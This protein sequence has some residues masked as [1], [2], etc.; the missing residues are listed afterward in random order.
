MRN[1]PVSRWLKL[2]G[3]PTLSVLLLLLVVLINRQNALL[4]KLEEKSD[5]EEVHLTGQKPMLMPM[6]QNTTTT[7]SRSTTTLA[8]PQPRGAIVILAGQRNANTYWDIAR[9][10]LLRRA[11][12][13]IDEHINSHFGPYPIFV[14]VARDYDQDPSRRDA[15]YTADDRTLVESWATHSHMHWE[16]IDLYSGEALEPD[17][18]CDQILS[19]RKGLDGGVEGVSLGY[20]SMCR[21]WSGW[22]QSMTFL[23]T[24]EY[25]MRIDDDSL[26]TA[27]PPWDPFVHMHDR[28]L[29]YLFR[30]YDGDTHGIDKLWMVS[31]EYVLKNNSMSHKISRRKF[32]ERYVGASGSVVEYYSGSQPYNNFHISKVDFWRSSQWQQL[33]EDMDDEH[34]F[35]KYRVGDANVH[36]MAIMMMGDDQT[37]AFL[38]FPYVHNVNDVGKKEWAPKHW[39]TEC[40]ET[41]QQWHQ[42]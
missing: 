3:S 36:A 38:D 33:M 10:C 28:S 34:L 5:N 32:L 2:F 35:F 26:I 6:P 4:V 27:K 18:T 13:S 29:S 40:D 14:V 1:K 15:A 16:E 31:S 21:L 11:I 19:W 22:L 23:D 41:E 20:Q 37:E 39:T 42:H 7:P 9:F 25:Y 12:R 17:T 24:F 8:T 30:R